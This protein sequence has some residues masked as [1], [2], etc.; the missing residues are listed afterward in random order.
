MA[1]HEQDGIGDEDE[2]FSEMLSGDAPKFDAEPDDKGSEPAALEPEKAG[3]ER[4][5]FG[6]FKAKASD[7]QEQPAEAEP[8]KQEP[9]PAPVEAAAQEP[10][11][12]QPPAKEDDDGKIPSWRMREIREARDAERNARLAAEQKAA[13]LETQTQQAFAAI[14]HLQQQ[15]HALQ[16]PQRQQPQTPPNMFEDPDGFTGHWDQRL[17]AI[18][19]GLKGEFQREIRKVRLESNLA[20]TAHLYKE[21]FPEALQAFEQAAVNDQALKHR[22]FGS[23]DPGGAIVAWHKERKAL[24][25]IGGDPTSY[26][27]RKLD[28]ALKDPA[29]LAKALEAAR[30]QAG[31][32]PVVS[33]TTA[34][35]AARP[36]TV[37]Q[38][39]P[40]LRSVPGAAAS[41]QS[42]G[43]ENLNDEELFDSIARR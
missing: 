21:E 41:S 1:N 12:A 8:Q 29:F 11:A 27:Q 28:E 31:G 38:L 33:T 18:E 25:E 2:L 24:Q 9:T 43:I 22:V 36:N 17:S 26:V 20:T 14:Q 37:T 6:R 30:A 35:P 5:E 16:N 34:Q 3:R 7:T 19:N 42:T 40:S 39:P 23:A 15:L 10:A 4:D 32:Q 13:A